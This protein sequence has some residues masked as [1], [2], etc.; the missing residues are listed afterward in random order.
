MQRSRRNFAFVF[1]VLAATLAWSTPKR[2]ANRSISGVDLK[3]LSLF[4]NSNFLSLAS[5]INLDGP[6]LGAETEETYVDKTFVLVLGEADKLAQ[7]FKKTNSFESYAAFMMGALAVPLHESRLVH[8]RS[9]PKSWCDQERNEASSYQKMIDREKAK[10]NP[11]NF[12]IKNMQQAREVHLRNFRPQP[13]VDCKDIEVE[14]IRQLLVN[15]GGDMGLMQINMMAHERPYVQTKLYTST[16]KSVQYGLKIFY[17]AFFKVL[18]AADPK[19][20]SCLYENG[21]LSLRNVIRGTYAGPYNSGGL[22]NMCRFADPKNVY[23]KHSEGFNEALTGLESQKSLFDLAATPE[24]QGDL[25]QL[26]QAFL[27]K[28]KSINLKTLARLPAEPTPSKSTQVVLYPN[29]KKGTLRAS[30]PEY[31]A[32]PTLMV[33]QEPMTGTPLGSLSAKDSFEVLGERYLEPNSEYPWYLVSARGGKLKGWA[34]GR[35]ITIKASD[36]K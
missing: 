16:Q 12:Y 18:A 5:T 11:R 25:T 13:A 22:D 4:S 6:M 27:G 10:S 24:E 33:R 20:Y 35:H 34:G 2:S 29:A 36:S 3:L 8:F 7:D 23:F 19:K 26:R 9:G 15:F 1:G 28:S 30:S 14:P 17:N 21:K 32:V 31:D